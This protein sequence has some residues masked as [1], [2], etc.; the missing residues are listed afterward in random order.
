MGLADATAT[1]QEK[2]PVRILSIGVGE[3]EGV[4]R[5][6]YARVEILEILALKGVEVGQS[7]QVLPR[8]LFGLLNPTAARDDRT[9]AGVLDRH[10]ESDE[11]G[12]LAEFALHL[13]SWR[14]PGTV[15]GTA[16]DRDGDLF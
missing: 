4:L 2:P 1:V 13:G 16:A 8:P 9:E 12:I 14:L 7:T 5:S 15:H 6:S 11:A 3:V 10:I